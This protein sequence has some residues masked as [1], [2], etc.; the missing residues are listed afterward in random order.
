[1][2]PTEKVMKQFI[3]YMQE[4]EDEITDEKSRK[5]VADRFMEEYKAK[6]KNTPAS[7]QNEPEDAD[8]YL[9]LAKQTYSQKKKLEY[10]N[11]ALE[12][13]PNNVD[14]KHQLIVC[15]YDKKLNECRK[16]M[17]ELL[18]AEAEHLEKEGYF[19]KST[20]DFWLVLETRPYMRLKDNYMSL[21]IHLGMI[22]RAIDEGTDML[23]LCENDNLGIRYRLMHLY[24]YMEDELH[25]VALHKKFEANDD[26][27]M[28]LPL[29]IL[30]YKLGEEE[31]AAD[32]LA[33][34]SKCN[35]DTKKFLT[36]LA[37]GRL[38]N[39]LNMADDGYCPNTYEELQ[40]ELDE[41]S[42][43]FVSASGFP[44]WALEHLPKRASRTK[45]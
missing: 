20:G 4:H 13:E 7:E 22:H 6:L 9:M 15:T 3:Q 35:K 26:T 19:K 8:D 14:A 25:A 40:T 44:E 17:Q 18:K 2:N 32:Y 1:M 10:L 16:A 30:Y 39:I 12:L 37:K 38:E 5:L 31:Q 43:L 27:Q 23:R 29:S 41:N 45:K 28:L 34:L 42:F 11:K 33:Q 21:L 36:D 24:A